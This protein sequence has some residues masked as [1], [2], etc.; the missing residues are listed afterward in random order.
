MVAVPEVCASAPITVAGE[1]QHGVLAHCRRMVAITGSAMELLRPES[2][3]LRSLAGVGHVDL[4]VACADES[5]AAPG[6]LGVL[7]PLGSDVD[8]HSGRSGD[9]DV[10]AFADVDDDGADSC[11]DDARRAEIEAEVSRLGLPDLHVHRLDLRPPLSSSAEPDLVAALSEL[12]GFDP[13]PGVY[14][15]APASAPGD[16]GRSALITAAQRIAQ[17]YGLPLLRY[18]CLELAV[19][20]EQR[21]LAGG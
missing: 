14:C 9:A 4:L 15:L 13:E 3:L 18:R 19:V 7:P 5:V 6:S 21:R 10:D 8:V 20:P 16:I 12:V 11:D 1:G 2:D 17:I